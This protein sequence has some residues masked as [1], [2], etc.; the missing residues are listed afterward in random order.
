M[1][2]RSS[3]AQRA[4][5][6]KTK[7]APAQVSPATAVWDLSNPDWAAKLLA[8]ESLIPPNLP[9]NHDMAE[10]AV[11]AFNMLRLADV[12]GTPTLEE[13]G[14]EWFR[15]IVRVVFGCYDPVLRSRLI[16]ELF[17]LVPKKN[18]KTTQGALL[19]LLLLLFNERPRGHAIMTAPVKD[20]AQVAF[21]AIAGAIS[22]D[23]VLEKT[24]YVRGNYKLIQHRETKATLQVMTFDPEVLT[25]QKLF[26]AL[27]DELHV[28]A[29]ALKAPSALRQIRGGMVPFPES[30]LMFITTQSETAPAGVFKAELDAARDIRDGKR[31]NATTLPILYE[32]PQEMQEDPSKPWRNP[33]LWPAVTPNQDRSIDIDRLVAM[34]E[35]AESRGEE[36]LRAFASQHLNIQIGVA[37]RSDRWAGAQLWESA[38]YAPAASLESLLEVCEVVEAGVDGGGLDD[39][40]S[41]SIV[42][43]ERVTKRWLTWT[44]S[45]VHPVVFNKHRTQGE[46]FKDFEKA[47]ELRIVDKMGED[48]TELVA[49]IV[50]CEKAGV[51]DRVGLDPHGVGSIVDALL[52]A[53]IGEDRILGI[54]QGWRLGG[55][56]KTTERALA[57]GRMC[58]GGQSI[59]AWCVGNAK[60]EPRGNAILIT[61]QASGSC[62]IDPLMATFNAVHLIASNPEAKSR[63]YQMFV[64]GGKQ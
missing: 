38:N 39:L 7:P 3:Q 26:A 29:K 34:M 63:K 20:V 12:P 8:G 46:I 32:F 47:D 15:D 27:V 19:M 35:D 9:L 43:R 59:M 42:G 58:H 18:A 50:K 49:C 10:R 30:M 61:K 21:D 2:K 48:I 1:V 22:L 17:L 6:R 24:F 54:S 44:R 33:A 14:G 11:C 5:V 37:L 25:G 28:V 36:E 62:K 40:L 45:W 52:A 56:I 51:L 60:V 57:E 53:G 16:R 64:L 41:L 13:A 4:A 23:P 55:A 31:K